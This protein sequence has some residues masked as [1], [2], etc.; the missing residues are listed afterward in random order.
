[1]TMLKQHKKTL[2]ITSALILLPIAA[3]LLLWD[4]LPATM[5]IHWNASGE[6]DGAAGKGFAIF[7]IPLFLLGMHW[8]CALI[9]HLTNQG[10][11]QNKKAMKIV[12]W[13]MPL[14]CNMAMG[15]MYAAALGME[16]DI[17]RIIFL[18]LGILFIII[19]NFMPKFRRNTTMGIK[20]KW[21]LADDEN[22]YSTHRFAGKVWVMGGAAVLFLSFLPLKWSIPTL[23]I[24]IF[25]LAFAPVIYSWR[26]A[27]KQKAEG[28]E[29]EPYHSPLGRWIW[30]FPAV[31]I[32]VL[33][34]ILFTGS[35]TFD[36]GEDAM[37]VDA[38]FW[39]PITL[40]YESIDS[41]ELCQGS[42]PGH[43]DWGYGSAR[44]L[45][46]GFSSE[47]LGSY[48]RYTYTASDSY[49]LIHTGS[50]TLVLADKDSTATQALY[51]AILHKIG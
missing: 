7:F 40:E 41:I 46:G 6:A 27:V 17:S 47:E 50:N 22:W 18:P 21:A 13:T 20:T 24:S 16:F 10:N 45:L 36:L 39:S 15:A 48:T 30:I 44:L 31:L 37:T 23:F 32:P 51:E 8:F 33:A 11:D 29:V 35:I 1:M 49:I 25:A 28:K 42:A 43:R 2:L 38:A 5:N 19:G 26:F 14:I 9:T 12:L 3:G 4:Q 34:V